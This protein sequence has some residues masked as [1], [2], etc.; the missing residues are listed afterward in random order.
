MNILQVIGICGGGLGRHVRDLCQDLA[1]QGNRLTV[2]Y[3][4]HTVDKA[5]QRFVSE[6]G[7]EILFI[8]LRVRREISPISDLRAIVQLLRL[9]RREGPFNIVHGHSAKGGAI[10]RIAGYLSGIPTVYTPHSLIMSSPEVS[11]MKVAAYTLIERLLGHW[12]TSKIIAVSEDERELILNLK[13]VPD[14]DLVAL[15]EN[16]IENQDFEYSSEESICERISQTPLTF[17][18]ILRFTAQK[19]PGLLVQAFSRINDE[20]PH[21]PMRLVLAGDGELFEEVERQVEAEGLGGKVSL[22]GWRTDVKEVLRELDVFVLPSLYE[23]FSYAILEAMA[24][25]LPIVSTDVFGTKETVAQ[26][27][28]N[29]VVPI[30]KPAA[31]AEGMKKMA[32]LAEP[33]LLR[34]TLHSIG[35]RNRNYVRSHFST[36]AFTR[37]T[38]QIYQTLCR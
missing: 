20:L 8:P 38:L 30:G 26:V 36:S 7:D 19:A 25:S 6:R 34:R 37:R 5:F 33:E 35:E 21:I 13:L 14:S 17:G 9:I 22:L 29:V 16:G 15:V 24:A 28:G 32:T 18:T 23:G 31:L 10:A 4:P 1:A 2:V 27:S 12:A 11:H 3:A